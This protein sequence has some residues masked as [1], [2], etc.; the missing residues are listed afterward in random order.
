MPRRARRPPRPGLLAETRPLRILAQILAL[1]AVYY[2][3]ALVLTVFSCLAAGTPMLEVDAGTKR[4]KITG[5]VLGWE[6][7]RGDTAQGFVSALVWLLD[8]GFVM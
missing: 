8:G 4:W 6:S 2:A 7:V 5:M 3:A 1:Q